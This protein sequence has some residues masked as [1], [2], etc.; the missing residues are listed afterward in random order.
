MQK[1]IRKN[2]KGSSLIEVLVSITILGIISLPLTTSFLNSAILIRMTGERQELNSVM[3]TIKENV[4]A[5]VKYGAG[6]TIPSYGG[7]DVVLKDDINGSDLKIVNEIGEISKR[8]KF[9]AVRDKDFGE[10]H[11]F[12]DTCEY[13]ITVKKM[14][15]EVFQKLRININRLI[16]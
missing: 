10:I 15:G 12:S 2:N 6:N 3:R 9:D 13:L 8:F 7:G 11:G 16:P 14:D 5:S 4:I 1:I